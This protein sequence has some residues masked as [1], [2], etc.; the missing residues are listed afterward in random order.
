MLPRN[1]VNY[2]LEGKKYRIFE[3][4][5]REAILLGLGRGDV[6]KEEKEALIRALVTFE[7]GCGSFYGNR[8]YFLAAVELREFEE[9]RMADEIIFQI[10]RWSVSD[11]DKNKNPICE[12]AAQTAFKNT[13]ASVDTN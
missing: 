13:K 1:H 2:P 6:D 8:A 7:D 12:I 5:W 3:S 4:P 11:I 9:C 10:L